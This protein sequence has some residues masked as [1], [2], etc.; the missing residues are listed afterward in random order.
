M[1]CT[2]CTSLAKNHYF[3]PKIVVFRVFLGSKG[4]KNQFFKNLKKPFL[5]GLERAPEP[6]FEVSSSKDVAVMLPTD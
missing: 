6:K 2:A 3:G 5:I 4:R 1:A